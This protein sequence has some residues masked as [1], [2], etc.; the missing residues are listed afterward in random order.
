MHYLPETLR[1]AYETRQE[2]PMISRGGASD[3]LFYN[4][5]YGEPIPAKQDD[6][7]RL[8]NALDAHGV[9][10]GV[11]SIN[12]PGVIGFPKGDALAIARDANDELIDLVRASQGRTVGLA[13]LPWQDPSVALAEFERV[14]GLGLKGAMLY[15]NIA[16]EAIDADKFD[17]L[18]EAAATMGLP[19][20]LHP[21][22]PNTVEQLIDYEVL[23][24]A[25][26]FL[27][28]TTTA[29]LRLISKGVLTR[30]PELKILLG[31][32]GSLLPALVGRLDRE[33]ERM[34]GRVEMAGR[35]S[36]LIGQLYTDTVAGS[37]R[38]LNWCL[39]VFGADRIMF[40]S[41]FPFWSLGEGVELL[42][43][44]DLASDQRRAIE[45]DT[46]MQLFAIS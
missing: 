14:A 28:D 36:D 44:V 20:L 37:A 1:A 45:A 25:V 2:P 29:A 19:L 21:I 18:F 42:D 12:Q 43:T 11:V 41:D 13:T 31:H 4:R 39:D 15:S 17:P 33:W 30:R 7:A 40:G 22:L 16:G 23:V 35:P 38:N 34:R 8:R 32:S 26:G 27:F 24:P 9:D 6:W 5:R 10:I 46:A 3:V